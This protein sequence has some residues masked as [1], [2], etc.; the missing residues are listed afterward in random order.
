MLPK[1]EV[2]FYIDLI[3]STQTISIAPYHLSRPFQ[4]EL[5]KQLD[6]L[7]SKKLIDHSV[8]PWK[9]RVLFTKKDGSLRMCVDY[10]GFNAVTIKIKYPL[11]H[12]D[13][14]FIV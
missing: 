2:E 4:K 8:S 5:R 12:I 7:L 9:A 10:R 3:P 6:D 14:L 11:P 13:E 1:R